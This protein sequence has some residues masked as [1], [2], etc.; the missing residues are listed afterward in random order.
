MP[1][2]TECEA[3]LKKKKKCKFYVL[4]TF[5]NLISLLNQLVHIRHN[6]K[7]D[8]EKTRKKKSD[9][10]KEVGSYEAATW[11]DICHQLRMN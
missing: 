7:V 11:V 3:R 1:M 10:T 8:T 5:V 2:T 9:G 6:V 4:L